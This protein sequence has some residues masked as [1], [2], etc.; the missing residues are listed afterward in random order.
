MS[1]LFFCV[2]GLCRQATLSDSIFHKI[3]FNC[4][5]HFFA[6]DVERCGLTYLLHWV[7][8]EPLNIIAKTTALQMKL[9]GVFF[10]LINA[11]LSK[12]S[13]RQADTSSAPWPFSAC[14]RTAIRYMLYGD[15]PTTT[16]PDDPVEWL[17]RAMECNF[18][19]TTSV[20]ELGRG[21]GVCCDGQT[22]VSLS[23]SS[24]TSVSNKTT[25]FPHVR[26]RVPFSISWRRLCN[27]L[28]THSVIRAMPI[29]CAS[30][31]FQ[32]RLIVTQRGCG[33][34]RCFTMSCHR[35]SRQIPVVSTL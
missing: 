32:S 30:Q 25:T 5:S 6:P 22:L 8:C 3:S 16:G 7:A 19:P 10:A 18:D 20:L 35:W 27:D 2:H 23:L 12:P 26:R 21:N 31:L 33:T 24:Q 14:T 15:S 29:C 11:K 4:P 13:D 9:I 1:V 17:R 34:N 28:H